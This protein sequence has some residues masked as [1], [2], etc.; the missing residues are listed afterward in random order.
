[1]LGTVILTEIF[2]QAI[3]VGVLI[4]IYCSEETAT[5]R[6]QVLTSFLRV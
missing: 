2:T 5:K 6:P 1:M 4:S 3:K